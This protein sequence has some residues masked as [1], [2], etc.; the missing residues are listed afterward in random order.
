MRPYRPLLLGCALLGVAS[1]MASARADE[2]ADAL[3]KKVSQRAHSIQS[4]TADVTTSIVFHRGRQGMREMGKGRLKFESPNLYRVTFEPPSNQTI[5]SDGDTRYILLPHNQY[6]QAP[7]GQDPLDM[8][9]MDLV[10]PSIDLAAL[11]DVQ[12]RYLGTTHLDNITYR[13]LEKHTVQQ[14]IETTAKYY[15]APNNLVTRS[16]ITS[17]MGSNS[18]LATT[19]FTDIRI[20]PPLTV[21]EFQYTPPKTAR[22]YK[23]PTE[24]DETASLVP[25]GKA[26]PAFS[27]PTPA[28][29]HVS[30][31]V[32]GKGK[33]AI[34]V[35]FWFYT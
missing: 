20:N 22:L 14:S 35:N 5:I 21:A 15:V 2:K 10:P 16:V 28:G 7:A 1:G 6:V 32:A 34:L 30:L 12:F 31:A 29:S 33:K 18:M 9:P 3:L 25:V 23:P 17:T 4:L 27:L 8:L 11:S 26:A 24:Q 13:I 19:V